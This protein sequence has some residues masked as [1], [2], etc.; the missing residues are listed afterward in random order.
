MRCEAAAR[1]SEAA[2]GVAHRVGEARAAGHDEQRMALAERAE[3]GAQPPQRVV[4]GGAAETAADLDDGQH[5]RCRQQHG[6]RR[7]GRHLA[8][9]RAP[10]RGGIG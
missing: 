6:E 4:A 2:V 10:R 3:R 7:G 1:Q 8:A 5:S 9:G